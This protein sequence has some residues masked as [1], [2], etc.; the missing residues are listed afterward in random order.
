MTIGEQD[1][2]AR[3]LHGGDMVR[4]FDLDP[5]LLDGIDPRVSAHLRLRAAAARIWIERGTWEP[6]AE[7]SSY[8]ALGF[9]VLD[10]LLVRWIEI[11]GRRSAE[12]VGAGDLIRPWDDGEQLVAATA[13]W[14]AVHPT[15][16]AVLDEHVAALACRWPKI[17]DHL[18]S[19]SVQRSRSLATLHAIAHV[20]GADRRMRLVLWHL[21]GR[22]G[23][24]TPAGVHLPLR[25]TH[26]ILGDLAC[27]R[28]PTASSLLADLCRQGEL[29]RLDDGTWLLCG[30][31]PDVAA[32]GDQALSEV[33]RP[34]GASAG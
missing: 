2:Q 19:R 20:R 12:L 28:R 7:G 29:Q 24:V 15:S 34:V 17:V 9:L 13:S 10:G 1:P 16:I 14:T 6:T 25:L 22:W 8:G 5:D 31:P 4:V 27:M 11:D 26:E 30:E 23:R 21:A 33:G 32:D 18:V 3:F